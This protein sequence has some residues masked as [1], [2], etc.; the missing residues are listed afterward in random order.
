MHFLKRRREPLE[1]IQ[2]AYLLTVSEGSHKKRSVVYELRF[3]KS[4]NFLLVFH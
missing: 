4:K 3:L 1:L 2:L